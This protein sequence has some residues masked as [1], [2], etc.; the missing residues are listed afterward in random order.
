MK[1]I[2]F[3]RKSFQGAWVISGIIGTRQYMFY[4]RQNA[5]KQ[6]NQE[7]KFFIKNKALSQQMVDF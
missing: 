1:Y 2:T 3:I 4:T 7:S 6:Y 5:I